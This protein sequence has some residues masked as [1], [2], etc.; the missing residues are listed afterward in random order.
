MEILFLCGAAIQV[1]AEPL[2]AGEALLA[3]PE[4]L[5]AFFSISTFF[6]IQTRFSLTQQPQNIFPINRQKPATGPL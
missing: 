1:P 2:P 5:P 4:P 6:W 3:G